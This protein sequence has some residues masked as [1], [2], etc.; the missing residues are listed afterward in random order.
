MYQ[1][2]AKTR[3]NADPTCLCMMGGSAAARL[4]VHARHGGMSVA[5]LSLQPV[6]GL[7]DAFCVEH[8]VETNLCGQQHF[9][10]TKL[11]SQNVPHPSNGAVVVEHV[12]EL[13][14]MTFL[15][16]LI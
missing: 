15:H 1:R 11:H 9:V 10:R 14:D 16:T 7:G 2:N 4:E 12:A 6:D 3:S 5:D 8:A 13:C